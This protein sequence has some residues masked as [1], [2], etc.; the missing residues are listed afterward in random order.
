MNESELMR[1]Y[2]DPRSGSWD[3]VGYA[4]F[5]LGPPVGPS[6]PVRP[7]TVDVQ[8]V[9]AD[10]DVVV[11][12]S[13]AGGGVAARV[14]AEAGASVLIIERGEW[15][16]RDA[17]TID[18]LHN[19]RLPVLGDGTSPEGYLRAVVAADGSEE[20]VVAHDAR[21]GNNALT[22]G[23]G[24]RMFGAQAWRFHPD[25]FRMAT[26]YGIPEG[27]ALA[28]WPITY[29]DLEPYYDKVEWELGVAGE[30]TG[31][32]PRRRAY[33]MAPW[34][35]SPE[36]QRLAT[37]ARQLDWSTTRVPLLI[38]TEPRDGRPAC[39]RC[40]FCVGFPCPVD[41]KNGT[42]TAALPRATAAG[43]HLLTGAQAVR[44]TDDGEVELIVNGSA[45]TV[46][47]GQIALAG[48]AIETARLLQLSGIGNDWVGDCLQAHSYV[49]A[50]GHFEDV[51][52]DGLGP[53]PSIASLE[54][55]HG[56]DGI[57]GGG[58]LASDFI[59]LPAFHYAFALAPGTPRE[60]DAAR[61][62]VA[63]SYRRTVQVWAP[64]QE[65]PTREAQVR[66]AA[67][68]TDALGVPVARLQGRQH[69]EDIRGSDFLADRAQEW[70]QAAG[71]DTIWQVRRSA[72]SLSAGQ[73]QAGTARMSDTPERGATDTSGRVWG[74]DRIYVVDASVHVTNGGVN[75]VLTIMATAWRTAE[76]MTQRA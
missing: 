53:G 15:V 9:R 56:N 32:H 44:I 42:G 67:G 64:F 39:I 6:A 63:E 13:G 51:V 20:G 29:E 41:A 72:R 36:G 71:A 73:H 35:L 61:R 76:L 5:P 66:L 74:T 46:R 70:L 27:S 19:P 65:I 49:G 2:A 48:G 31:V 7:S 43:A 16:D 69:S 26:T 52:A 8:D 57:V 33:P 23:G 1:F 54:F 30:P 37:A 14:L 34:P 47:A 62:A 40:G 58:L 25:D 10:Y 21:A 28:D 17:P 18:H 3:E 60:G 12:G 59:R 55:L 38:N 4:A 75:P 50:Y 22:V 45:M 68:V 11:I 24:T